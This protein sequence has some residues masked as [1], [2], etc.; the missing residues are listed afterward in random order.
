MSHPGVATGQAPATAEFPSS[1][2]SRRL[3]GLLL[4]ALWLT[5]LFV[6]LD[7]AALPLLLCVPLALLALLLPFGRRAAPEQAAAGKGHSFVELTRHLSHAT[8][9]N[10]LAAASV[11]W[12]VDLLA[13]RVQSQLGAAASI[14]A[15]ADT[16]IETEAATASLSEK[17][18]VAAG[19]AFRSSDEGR[20]SLAASIDGM[21][22]LSARAEHSREAIEVLE[23]R[24]ED[25]QRVAQVIQSIASQ[26]NLLALN[27]AIEA[28]RAGEH[29]RGFAVVAD[30]VRGLAARTASATGEVG[31]MVTDIQHRTRTAVEQIRALAVDLG[32]EV[33]RVEQAG[34]HLQRIAELAQGVE[35][36]MGSIAEGASS[37]REQLARLFEGVEQMRTD[38]AISETQTQALAQ[39]AKNM[40]GQ[41]EAISERLSEVGLDEY[42]QRVYDLAVEGAASITATFEADIDTG[43]VSLD[44][45]FDRGYKAIPNTHPSKF[46]TRFDR[47]TDT[48]L[49]GI[50]E[51]LLERHPGLVFAIACTPQGYVPTHNRAFSLA[52][53]GDADHDRVWSRSKRKFADR[54]G[55]RCGSHQQKMLLQTYTRDTGEL[56]HDL[57]VPIWVKGRHWGG[58]RLGYRPAS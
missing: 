1:H 58:L 37:N 55:I 2:L 43:R 20:C 11:A 16:M 51:P 49:P 50:Q 53:T 45:L 42:H 38:L 36:Q 35:A 27:A 7:Y 47:Y 34:A 30:E 48:V 15:S 19:Q 31:E 44:D 28:A 23:Q 3:P 5:S 25:I 22:R 56:M 33:A 32:S 17:A 8:S 39:A 26:T 12:S 6:A 24:S 52:P 46:T 40:E 21:H 4:Q 14:V 29:G 9:Q 57:S 41:A 13:G 54:T 10:A 18:L